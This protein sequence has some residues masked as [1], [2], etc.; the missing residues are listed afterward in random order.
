MESQG[1]VEKNDEKGRSLTHL[2]AQALKAVEHFEENDYPK[3]SDCTALEP[4]ANK[5]AKVYKS[6][7]TLVRQIELMEGLRSTYSQNYDI[8]PRRHES[9]ENWF[10]KVLYRLE[11]CDCH[12]IPTCGWCFGNP[13]DL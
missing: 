5:L 10:V 11:Y 9:Q 8:R 13:G 1:A 7:S 12:A 2:L 6:C 4:L 3:K